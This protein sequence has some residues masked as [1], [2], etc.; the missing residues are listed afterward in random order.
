MSKTIKGKHSS[1]QLDG[2]DELV[3]KLG[4]SEKE[5]KEVIEESLIKS[6]EYPKQSM[7]KYMDAHHLTGVTE[8][9]YEDIKPQWNGTTCEGTTGFNI[10]KGG[11]PA[12]FLHKGTPKIKPSYFVHY[13]LENSSRNIRKVQEEALNKIMRG[14]K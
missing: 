12:L 9:S 8:K 10:Y 3:K 4:K 7:Q 6:A 14:V 11:L 5:I 13:A 2:F 1:I